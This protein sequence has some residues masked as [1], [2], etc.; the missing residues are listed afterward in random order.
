MIIAVVD[1][2]GGSI[3]TQIVLE[4]RRC[5]PEETE[6]MALGTNAIA[7]GSMMKAKATRGAT[8]ENAIVYSIPE[9]GLIMGSLSIVVPNSMM[10]EVSP[11]IATAIAGAPGRKVL[12]PVSNPPLDIMGAS[13]KPLQALI[14]E[15]IEVVREHFG[16]P[17]G[18]REEQDV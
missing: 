16:L 11:A 13:R 10:G 18:P 8:G 14:K 4:L 17:A 12:L 5:L 1:G 15:A 7:T 6:I 9:A 3:G 2:M